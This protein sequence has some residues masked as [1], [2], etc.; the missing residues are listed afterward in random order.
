MKHRPV[1]RC[2]VLMCSVLCLVL[3]CSVPGAGS[4]DRLSVW[5]RAV[6]Q[7]QPAALDE[8]VRAIAIWTEADLNA[9]LALAHRAEVSSL[10]TRLKRAAWLHADVALLHRTSAGYGVAA[11]GA[12]ATGVGDGQVTGAYRRTPHWAFA[13]RLLQ[14]SHRLARAESRR[15]T[16][17][18][19]LPDDDA[20][21]W[22]RATAAFLQSWAEYVE[23]VPHLSNAL[24][25]FPDDPALLLIKGSMHEYFAESAIQVAVE[26]QRRL[27]Q[28]VASVGS[29]RFEREDA[30]RALDAAVR[31]DPT[32][33]EARIRR[34]NVLLRLGR[35]REAV[36]TVTPLLDS[37]P[38]DALGYWLHL[39]HGRALLALDQLTGARNAFEAA[40]AMYPDAQTPRLALAQVA[41]R[42][43]DVADPETLT[44]RSGHAEDPWFQY[45]ENH[46]PHADEWVARLRARWPR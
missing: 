3:W 6:D 1:L 10:E 26:Q 16:G 5:L 9:V 4:Q 27:K 14:E 30:L 15:L 41:M 24:A 36:D 32:M 38:N 22:H 25:V 44:L 43:G 28:D 37:P 45:H 19:P 34:A 7:H 2:S 33:S 18:D 39:T 42:L 21:L 12:A 11:T 40:M 17:R 31:L 23:L 20:R 13:R 35:Y 8:H 29:I 46:V